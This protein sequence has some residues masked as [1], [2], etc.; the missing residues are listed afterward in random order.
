MPRTCVSL[1][2]S[3][4]SARPTWCIAQILRAIVQPLCVEGYEDRGGVVSWGCLVP[5]RVI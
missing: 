5:G 1:A 2:F 4:S 3:V